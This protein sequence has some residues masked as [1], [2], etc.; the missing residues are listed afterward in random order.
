MRENGIDQLFGTLAIYF[1][2]IA[3]FVFATRTS[4]TTYH[5]PT[6]NIPRNYG[7]KEP[8]PDYLDDTTFN[9]LE[10]PTTA[11][12]SAYLTMTTTPSKTGSSQDTGHQNIFLSPVSS[13]ATLL[14][15]IV[16][17]IS[18]TQMRDEI[19]VIGIAGGS[20]SGKTTLSKAIYDA[21]GAENIC[22][23][24]HDSYY[25]DLSH[26]TLA[27]RENYNFDHPLALDTPLLISHVKAL[28]EKK[29]VHIPMYDFSIHT[30]RNE[31]E[32]LSPKPVIL[33]EGI[34]IFQEAAL[35][36]HFDIKIFVD[37]EDDIRLVRRIRRDTVERGRT[38]DSVLQQYIKTVRPMHLQFV[39]PSKRNADIIVPVGLNSVA[40]D[41]VVSKLK[42][43][44]NVNNM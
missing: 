18:S 36:E 43:H 21:I 44:L 11:A 20:G 38:I 8:K 40:L 5:N 17:K 35:F 2:T 13:S 4:N 15:P 37:T 29:T 23:I 25:K 30:R 1:T 9:I 10:S 28:K 12:N 33:V 27:E 19:I 34:L 3:F 41:L 14:E 42:S 7:T 6:S 24:S 16:S 32:I 22:Y 26:L 39:E 31:T